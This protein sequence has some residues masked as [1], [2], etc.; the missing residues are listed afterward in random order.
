MLKFLN[1]KS[2]RN[3]AATLDSLIP[4][5]VEPKKTIVEQI[6]SE[7][8]NASDNAIIEAKKIL[9]SIPKTSEDIETLGKIGFTN[10]KSVLLNRHAR[11]SRSNAE[12]EAKAILY[13]QQNLPTHKFIMEKQIIEIC[14]KY[15]LVWGSISR[16]IGDIP[17]K[18]IKEINNFHL[19]NPVKKEDRRI[20]S[21]ENYD[22]ENIWM[23]T[24]FLLSFPPKEDADYKICAP[25][26]DMQMYN[27]HIDDKTKQVVDDDPI[28]LYPVKDGYIIVSA[29]GGESNDEKVVN[30]K[31]N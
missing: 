4:I 8:N 23:A 31:M 26:K 3:N 13:W 6:H 28:V 5:Q 18:N 27:S 12:S 15:G 10:A 17:A 19:N 21:F 25:V 14:E 20:I 11:Q 22:P 29:W 7:F 24:T 1:F 30:Q 2:D 16:Y 9:N